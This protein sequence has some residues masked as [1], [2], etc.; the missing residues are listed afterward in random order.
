[1]T[2]FGPQPKFA[3]AWPAGSE[4]TALNITPTTVTLS[5]T[6]AIGAIKYRVYEFPVPIT[7]VSST[8][9][10]VTG[11]RIG[12]TYSFKVEAGDG[13]SNFTTNGPGL[14]VRVLPEGAYLGYAAFYVG[15][16]YPGGSTLIVNNFTALGQD[17]I[18]VTGVNMSGELGS[19][20]LAG[21]PLYLDSGE[22]KTAN[23]TIQIPVL[24]TP[25][26]RTVTIAVSWQYLSSLNSTWTDAPPI[27]I[28]GNIPVQAATPPSQSQGPN[29]GSTPSFTTQDPSDWLITM[30]NQYMLPGGAIL[31]MLSF[32]GLALVLRNKKNPPLSQFPRF[33]SKCGTEAESGYTFCPRCGTQLPTLAG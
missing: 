28:S 8:S 25:G 13:W 2:P 1:M 3:P 33:C 21:L 5:W 31:W 29:T 16:R 7:N 12:A 22:S 30:V 11:L 20:S 15:S 6:Q 18:R 26:N 9:F 14:T 32:L 27:I 23:M 4:L 17:A 19:F 10:T 24:A